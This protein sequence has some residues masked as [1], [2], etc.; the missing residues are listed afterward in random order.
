MGNKLEEPHI[1]PYLLHGGS[2]QIVVQKV[3]TQTEP[4]GCTELRQR[5]EFKET[6]VAI[7]SRAEYRRGGSYREKKSWSSG[8]P[9]RDIPMSVASDLCHA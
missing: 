5:W 1:C 6:K 4:S 3:V 9:K 2:F 8:D 7:I